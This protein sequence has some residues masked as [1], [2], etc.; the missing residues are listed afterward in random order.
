MKASDRITLLYAIGLAGAAGVS[1]YRGRRGQELMADV[2]IHGLVAGTALNVADWLLAGEG[3]PLAAIANPISSQV[4][5]LNRK[6]EK[7][8]G[9]MGKKAVKLLSD[10]DEDLYD[11]FKENGVKVGAIPPNPSLI[12]QDAN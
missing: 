1:Y 7:G 2:A 3:E 9:K 4:S 11:D 5:L 8:M 12:N 6:K 10:V